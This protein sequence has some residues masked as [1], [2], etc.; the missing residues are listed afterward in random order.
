[1]PREGGGVMSQSELGSS[2]LIKQQQM[3]IKTNY[4]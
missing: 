2:D 4:L 1:M 3:T